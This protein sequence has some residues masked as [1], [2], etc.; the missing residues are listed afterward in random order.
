MATAYS[1]LMSEARKLPNRLSNGLSTDEL[2]KHY[3]EFARL[4]LQRQAE[5]IGRER[6]ARAQLD[7]QVPSGPGDVAD[8]SVIDSNV[9]YF[10]N[11]A[12][13]QQKEL[14][15]IRNAL[16][17]MHRGV[18]GICEA[19]EEPISLERL[20]RLPYARLCVDCQA[21]SERKTRFPRI[22]I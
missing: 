4:L 18:Y 15:E 14:V 5:A 20:K 22:A 12:N 3:P 10:L 7:E 9:D 16:D 8:E 1:T 2:R 17:R 19:C 13:S 6:S 21:T 11:I